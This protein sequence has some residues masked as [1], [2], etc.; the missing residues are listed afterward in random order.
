MLR[1]REATC[2]S[3]PSDDEVGA[4]QGAIRAERAPASGA[5]KHGA[6]KQSTT[7]PAVDSGEQLVD[8]LGCDPLVVK[9][10]ARYIPPSH[11]T[12]QSD[13]SR[14]TVPPK[15][16]RPEVARVVHCPRVV[17]SSAVRS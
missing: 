8:D 12:V 9:V 1:R 11:G 16:T 7:S 17:C 10:R 4:L 15:I 6:I 13:Q 3:S 14:D 5:I 2:F